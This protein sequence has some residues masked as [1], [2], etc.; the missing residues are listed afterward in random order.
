MQ[1]EFEWD[2]AKAETNR[3]KHGVTFEQAMAEL[4]TD[5]VAIR[6]ISAVGRP[7]ARSA[8]M[9]MDD[10]MKNEYDFSSA[11]R[12][13]FFRKGARLMPPVHLEPDVLDHLAGLASARGVSLNE[14]VNTLLR[15]DI[16]RI[17]TAK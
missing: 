15:E 8:P 7:G 11:A 9:R 5:R 1:F 2:P 13:K 16:Q 14:L 4:A 10:P 3:R 6:I 12:G 17:E